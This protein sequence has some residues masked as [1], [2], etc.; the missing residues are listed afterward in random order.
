VSWN[1]LAAS[2]G[3]SPADWNHL[4]RA[5]SRFLSTLLGD[6][7][8]PFRR[9]VLKDFPRAKEPKARVPDLSPAVFWKIVNAAPVHLRSAYVTLAA[10][11]LRVGEYLRLTHAELR[12]ANY[13][14]RVR[15]TKTAGSDDVVVVGKAWW[16]WVKN[17]VPAPL[18]Y[19][20]LRKH[21]NRACSAVHVT[22]VTLHSLRH[23]CGQWAV[24]AG[25]PEAQVQAALRHETAST[26][27]IYT[28]Q[29]A[30]GQVARALAGVLLSRRARSAR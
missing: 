18:G 14:L 1:E 17:A 2:W 24:N 19:A 30:R 16:P 7:W 6:K 11:G 3:R 22:G 9:L 26:T 15:G 5:V 8:H 27:R 20:W 29:K 13:S 28:L 12:P 25:V 23:C 21:W 4:R 10:T